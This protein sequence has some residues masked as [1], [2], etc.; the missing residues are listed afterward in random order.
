MAATLHVKTTAGKKFSFEIALDSTVAQ[1][2]TALVPH[3]DVPESLQR[4]IYK[5]KVLKDEQTLASYGKRR[6]PVAKPV[7]GNLLLMQSMYHFEQGS[8]RTTRSSSSAAR[9]TRDQLDPPGMLG[10]PRPLRRQRPALRQPQELRS[11]LRRRPTRSASRC[12]RPLVLLAPAMVPT[13]SATC[14][15][16]ALAAAAVCPIWPR[17]SSR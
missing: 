9:R 13:R 10:P 16:L 1:C 12:S 5:G 11:Q 6:A 17:C 3:T 15:A 2:K 4:L 7:S 14:L 8:K